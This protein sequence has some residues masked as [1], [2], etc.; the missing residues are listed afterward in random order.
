MPPPN[1]RANGRS[2][3]SVLTNDFEPPRVSCQRGGNQNIAVS[4]Q[5]RHI[6]SSLRFLALVTGI[7]ITRGSVSYPCWEKKGDLVYL[8]EH[9]GLK[10]LF[11]QR[12]DMRVSV[13]HTALTLALTL[14]VA[15]E[16][17]FD[18]FLSFICSF[19][20]LFFI[21]ASILS[22]FFPP[23]SC[24]FSAALQGMENCVVASMVVIPI[25]P[26]MR[27]WSSKEQ[28]NCQFLPFTGRLAILTCM[29]VPLHNSIMEKGQQGLHSEVI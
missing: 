27:Q 17:S 24:S 4:L 11:P 1:K 16:P 15:R 28:N 3:P 29:C 26:L 5:Q 23:F 6:T 12:G 8:K 25:T 10:G 2:L 21:I 22:R 18:F 13:T 19:S 9:A 20:F 14:H 7:W